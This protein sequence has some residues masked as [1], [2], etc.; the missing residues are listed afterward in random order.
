MKYDLIKKE[1]KNALIETVSCRELHKNLEIKEDFRPWSSR[2]IESLGFE[3][4]TDYIE[5]EVNLPNGRNGI[6]Y[7]M[8]IEMAKHISMASRTA[9]GKETRTWFIEFEKKVSI[10][11]DSRIKQL[12][13]TIMYQNRLMA[14]DRREQIEIVDDSC[15]I[16][17]S[18]LEVRPFLK[19][20]WTP[21]PLYLELE[22]MGLIRK[23]LYGWECTDEGILLG[24]ETKYKMKNTKTIESIWAVFKIGVWKTLK[25][26]R[27]GSLPKKNVQLIDTKVIGSVN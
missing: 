25:P 19:N 27:V 21:Q 16:L 12:E 2:Q 18:A 20:D 5:V 11:F 10:E 22:S 14:N 26:Q 7:F 13:N 9:K 17:L 23:V 3:E 1:I 4:E 24:G 8:T 6:D 15:D